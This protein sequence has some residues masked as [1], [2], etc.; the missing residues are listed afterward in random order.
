MRGLV[1]A[2]LAGLLAMAGSLVAAAQDQP[3]SSASATEDSEAFLIE[4]Y[5]K[6]IAQRV[7]RQAEALDRDRLTGGKLTRGVYSSFLVWPPT[8][9]RINVCFFGGEPGLRRKVV[10]IA[11]EWTRVGGHVPLHFGDDPKSPQSCTGQGQREHIRVGFERDGTIWS[12]VGQQ[13]MRGSLFPRDRPSMNL[14]FKSTLGESKIRRAILHE[15]G[16]A[17]GLEHEHQSPQGK[18]WPD[19]FERERLVAYVRDNLG[20][21]ESDVRRNL[22]LLDQKGVLATEFDKV[23][24]MIYAFP[25]RFYKRKEASPCFA[26]ERPEISPGDRKLIAALYPADAA[27]RERVQAERKGFWDRLMAAVPANRTRSL[28]GRGIGQIVQEYLGAE[29]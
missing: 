16:H 9:A 8:L 10:A 4:A 5:P 6:D 3:A 17:L 29:R 27:A 13:S 1:C 18:C 19:E 28:D 14:G 21:G 12:A 25:A 7:G 23:S 24:V 11:S 15:F 22:A 20:W 26:T 2:L